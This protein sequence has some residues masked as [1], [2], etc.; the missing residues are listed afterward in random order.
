MK[1]TR[2]AKMKMQKLIFLVSKRIIKIL[3]SNIYFKSAWN[4][5]IIIVAR[6]YRK[7]NVDS[8]PL[9]EK[10][11]ERHNNIPITI[12]LTTKNSVNNH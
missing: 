5:A 12:H 2:I 10:I 1:I 8:A 7:T 9:S 4:I 3:W 6:L 11:F